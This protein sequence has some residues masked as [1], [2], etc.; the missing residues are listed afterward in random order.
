MASKPRILHVTDFF[1]PSAGG[2]ERVCAGLCAQL[3]R[4]GWEVEVLTP[5]PAVDGDLAVPEGVEVHRYEVKR[6]GTA[7]H[8]RSMFRSGR[9]AFDRVVG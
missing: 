9:E 3:V 6:N 2:V 7:A 1:P 4:A 5:A 8:Y